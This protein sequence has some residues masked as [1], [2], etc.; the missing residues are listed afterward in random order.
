M[1]T[2]NGKATVTR[3]AHVIAVGQTQRIT[4]T[5]SNTVLALAFIRHTLVTDQ[6][7]AI[8]T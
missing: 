8:L 7:E 5:D 4:I 3:G 6:S 2:V 1:K